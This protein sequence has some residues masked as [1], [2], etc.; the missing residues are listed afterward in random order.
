MRKIHLIVNPNGYTCCGPN[1]GGRYETAAS[2][3][4]VTCMKGRWQAGLAPSP[5]S[6][7]H[8]KKRKKGWASRITNSIERSYNNNLPMDQTAVNILS[9]MKAGG[10]RRL[11]DSEHT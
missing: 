7:T 3:E 9:M 8:Q 5:Y 1:E 10:W 2:K 6:S 11:R 4:Q